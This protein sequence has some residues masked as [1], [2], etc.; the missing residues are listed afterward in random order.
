VSWLLLI[1]GLWV[2]IAI[3]LDAHGRRPVPQ[4]G[5]DAVVVP[6]CKVRADGTPSTALARRVGHAAELWKAGRA[7]VI[8]L[9]GGVGH[10]PPSEAEAGAALAQDLGVPGAALMLEMR[11]TTTVENARFAAELRVDG[12]S[13]ARWRVL[14]VSDAYHAWRCGRLFGRHFAEAVG[15]GSVPGW[16]LRVRGSL[17]EVVSIALGALRTKAW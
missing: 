15:R 1:P 3:L 16:R 8:I 2:G 4:G 9:T 5:W 14:V 11:S 13:I 17:R 10:H 12:Q 6:G 7:P